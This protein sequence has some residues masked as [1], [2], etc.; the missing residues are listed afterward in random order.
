VSG[1]AKNR[2]RQPRLLRSAAALT[3][4]RLR[5]DKRYRLLSDNAKRALEAA[6]LQRLGGNGWF[7]WKRAEWGRAVGVSPRTISTVVANL[8]AHRLITREEYRRPPG[9]SYGGMNGAPNYRLHPSLFGLPC[10]DERQI[11]ER[12]ERA[13]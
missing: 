3:V 8:E 12:Q 1:P 2:P 6:I 10:W 4:E 7:D 13:S 11:E 9:G 5:N